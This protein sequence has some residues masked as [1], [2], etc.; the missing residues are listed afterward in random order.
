MACQTIWHRLTWTRLGTVTEFC[1][2]DHEHSGVTK[3]DEHLD[4]PD[5]Y[6]LLAISL[7]QIDIFLLL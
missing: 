1:E 6:L 5:G 2:W 4:Q 7:L 3:A